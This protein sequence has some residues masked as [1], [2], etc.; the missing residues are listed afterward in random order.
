MDHRITDKCAQIDYVGCKLR[1][2]NINAT[3]TYIH[4]QERKV[5]L[6]LSVR[7]TNAEILISAEL[8]YL[9]KI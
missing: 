8:T 3:C 9:L 5:A 2:I 7:C 6:L 4:M 1:A